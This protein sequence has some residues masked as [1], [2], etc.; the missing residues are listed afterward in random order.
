MRSVILYVASSL[1]GF[2]ARE[3]GSV[4]WLDAYES[5]DGNDYGY[6]AFLDSVDTLL[7]G[8]KTYRQVLGFGPYPYSDKRGYVFTRSASPR[9]DD[10]V[11]FVSGDPAAFVFGLIHAPG[12]DV[13]LVGGADIVSVLMS[14]GLVDEIILTLVPEVLGGGIPLFLPGVQARLELLSHRTWHGGVV[15]LRYSV[16]R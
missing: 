9:S 13:W 5:E 11:E 15:Q 4:D 6:Q 14:A 2:I 7:M 10:N 8:G 1:D 16:T 3:D 12:E